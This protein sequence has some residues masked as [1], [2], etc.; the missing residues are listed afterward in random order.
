MFDKLKKQ[1]QAAENLEKVLQIS[2]T[3]REPMILVQ[4]SGSEL[5]GEIWLRDGTTIVGA[6]TNKAE[7]GQEALLK[8]LDGKFLRFDVVRA[9]EDIGGAAFKVNVGELL[10]NR[11]RAIENIK[12]QLRQA[13]ESKGGIKATFE[14]ELKAAA[15]PQAA[16]NEVA[17]F[18]G[19]P[20]GVGRFSRYRLTGEDDLAAARRS[21][22][23]SIQ[24]KPGQSFTDEAAQ[25]LLAPAVDHL[26]DR[27]LRDMEAAA[28]GEIVFPRLPSDDPVADALPEKKAKPS[29]KELLAEEEALFP[30]REVYPAT[31]AQGSATANLLAYLRQS[32]GQASLRKHL[33]DG[34]DKTLAL[35]RFKEFAGGEKA[36]QQYFLSQLSRGVFVAAALACVALPLAGVLAYQ[37]AMMDTQ[38]DAEDAPCI[39]AEVYSF[40]D[41]PYLSRQQAGRH[42]DI[43]A[44][45]EEIAKER[46][47]S[48]P[49]WARLAGNLPMLRLSL[50]MF[51]LPD[52]HSPFR[53]PIAVSRGSSQGGGQAP[54]SNATGDYEEDENEIPS[55]HQPSQTLPP[56]SASQ[57]QEITQQVHTA[58]QL[59]ADGKL[60]D[61]LALYTELVA[62]F[63]QDKDLRIAAIRICLL[64]KHNAQARAWC[65]EGMRNATTYGDYLTFYSILDNVNARL[66]KLKRHQQR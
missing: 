55:W 47:D 14:P 60:S 58:E 37:R 28:R 9:S 65:I 16:A 41:Q 10:V 23:Q 33:K 22:L 1:I 57:L 64:N 19:S 38:I 18:E 59:I 32:D 48:L 20:G 29:A 30:V 44:A 49:A 45:Q 27:R 61:G 25:K 12:R 17:F 13:Q 39:N 11:H 5:S 63:P 40:L 43:A 3:A 46:A 8:L 26:A 34:L 35:F 24:P 51:K 2:L 42:F 53:P 4:L 62:K 66:Q 6:R 21:E 56:L 54:P 36:R 50:H 15:G 52:M 31:R 7:G